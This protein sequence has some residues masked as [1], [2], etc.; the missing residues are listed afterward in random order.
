[1][2]WFNSCFFQMDFFIQWIH[3]CLYTRSTPHL[4]LDFLSFRS[5]QVLLPLLVGILHPDGGSGGYWKMVF[6][7]A[8]CGAV[9]SAAVPSLRFA[10]LAVA[11][12]TVLLLSVSYTEAGGITWAFFQGWVDGCWYSF[13]VSR[14]WSVV[15]KSTPME[16]I[17]TDW[18]ERWFCAVWV[19]KDSRVADR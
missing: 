5:F 15:T 2:Y 17:V 14:W 6:A 1:M 18:V 16:L 3:T 8:A 9:I 13:I 11:I 10:I 12:V 19:K 4:L 7:S